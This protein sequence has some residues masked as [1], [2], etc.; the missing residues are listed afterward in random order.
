MK[1]D[2][3]SEY[4]NFTDTG[5]AESNHAVRQRVPYG[6][7]MLQP[8]VAI[9]LQGFPPAKLTLPESWHFAAVTVGEFPS[10]KRFVTPVLSALVHAFPSE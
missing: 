4:P 7:T 3:L 6:K 8:L 1:R 2:P 10:R 9:V 5:S